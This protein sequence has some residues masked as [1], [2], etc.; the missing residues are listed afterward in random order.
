[1]WFVGVNINCDGMAVVYVVDVTIIQRY[2]CINILVLGIN[3][4]W[5]FSIRGYFYILC[6]Q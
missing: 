2:M 4:V 1:M 6:N 5:M 3:V